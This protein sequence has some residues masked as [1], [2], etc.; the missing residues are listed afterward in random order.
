M[1]IYIAYTS[2]SIVCWFGLCIRSENGGDGSSLLIPLLVTA[3]LI[4]C[5]LIA[6]TS[7]I[8]SWRSRV[9]P[10]RGE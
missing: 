4:A 2:P 10:R 7:T 5:S 3:L 8:T 1:K 6:D 9:A